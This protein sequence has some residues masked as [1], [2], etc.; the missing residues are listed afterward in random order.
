MSPTI[1]DPNL[2]AAYLAAGYTPV[3]ENFVTYLGF[4]ATWIVTTTQ[5]VKQAKNLASPHVR[6][7]NGHT[8]ARVPLRPEYTD[9]GGPDAPGEDYDLHVDT[10]AVGG[11]YW[12]GSAEIPDGQRWASFGPAGLRMRFP[13]RETAEQVQVDAYLQRL[14]AAS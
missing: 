9:L 12:C 4:G 11:S 3:T 6:V 14:A 1:T 2:V 10:L 13:D 7:H 8:I 5:T